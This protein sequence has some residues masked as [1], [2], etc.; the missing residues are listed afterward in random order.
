[1]NENRTVSSQEL[2]QYATKLKN[3]TNTMDTILKSITDEVNNLGNAWKSTEGTM[4][5]EKY[6]NLSREINS[7]LEMLRDYA[8]RVEAVAQQWDD[9][10][11]R[12]QQRISGLSD[13]KIYS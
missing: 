3:S 5:S 9:F 7:S 12:G 11:A 6:Q 13:K 4:Y 2:R 1:M 10:A 8:G